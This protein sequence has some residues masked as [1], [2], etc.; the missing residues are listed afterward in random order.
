MFCV[1]D[2]IRVDRKPSAAVKEEICKK[3]GLNMR[4]VRV[5]FQNKRCKEKKDRMRAEGM[6]ELHHSVNMSTVSSWRC[7]P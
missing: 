7:S 3:T 2:T 6:E 1:T 4:V 5:W